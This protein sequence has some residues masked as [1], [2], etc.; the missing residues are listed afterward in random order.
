MSFVLDD[1]VEVIEIDGVTFTI[2]PDDYL[3]VLASYKNAREGLRSKGLI[4]DGSETFSLEDRVMLARAAAFYMIT[5]RIVSWSGIK[6]PD[7]TDAECTDE[8]KMKF[9]GRNPGAIEELFVRVGKKE[10]EEVKNFE[11]SQDG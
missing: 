10:E 4:D 11:T 8:N 9:F 2:R 3:D 7:G 1:T 6:Y 5:S